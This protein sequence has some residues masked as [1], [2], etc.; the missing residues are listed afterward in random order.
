MISHTLNGKKR[1]DDISIQDCMSKFEKHQY[2]ETE[3]A[4]LELILKYWRCDAFEECTRCG[5]RKMTRYDF[6]N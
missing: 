5:K 6:E 3:K 1:F 4:I 2:S